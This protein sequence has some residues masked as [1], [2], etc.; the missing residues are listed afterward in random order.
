MWQPAFV[1]LSVYSQ[2]S[3]NVVKGFCIATVYIRHPAGV[4]PNMW[5]TT[6]SAEGCALQELG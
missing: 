4:S 2:I 6:C 1:C 3:S 5:G